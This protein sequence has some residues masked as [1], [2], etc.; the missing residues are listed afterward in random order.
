MN[1]NINDERM[2]RE[3]RKSFIFESS[4]FLGTLNVIACSYGKRL[5]NYV[6][7]QNDFLEEMST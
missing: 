7:F 1:M 2:T 4:L 6:V 5:L 3:R